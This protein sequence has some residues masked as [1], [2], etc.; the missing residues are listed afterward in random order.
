MYGEYLRHFVRSYWLRE[1]TP[2]RRDTSRAGTA[3][4]RSGR[5]KQTNDREQRTVRNEMKTSV[6]ETPNK[7]PAMHGTTQMMFAYL[8]NARDQQATHRGIE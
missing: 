4:T 8:T 2:K 5:I 3:K 6:K 1:Q 7:K